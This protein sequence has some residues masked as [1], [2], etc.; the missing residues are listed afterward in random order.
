MIEARPA[1]SPRLPPARM[2]RI[3][4]AD[5]IPQD[6]SAMPDSMSYDVTKKRLLIGQGYVENV[7]SGMWNYQVSG[8]QVAAMVQLSQGQ[9]RTS[10][11]WRAPPSVASWGDPARSLARRIHDRAYK[12]AQCAWVARGPRTNPSQIVGP[13]LR[14]AYDFIG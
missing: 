11:H 4:A 3:P 14:R 10:N 8:K 7:E 5:A 2:P 9:P 1:Q 6:P 12:R 13:S